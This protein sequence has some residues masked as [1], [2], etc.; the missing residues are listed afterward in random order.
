MEAA[1]VHKTVRHYG[2]RFLC[3]DTLL[4]KPIHGLNDHARD[5]CHA[6]RT[7]TKTAGSAQNDVSLWDRA[8]LQSAAPWKPQRLNT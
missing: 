7:A 5:A 4:P 1:Q 2:L 3:C 8:R 6:G